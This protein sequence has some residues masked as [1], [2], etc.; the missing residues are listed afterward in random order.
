MT[1][2]IIDTSIFCLMSNLLYLYSFYF[3]NNS[4]VIAGLIRNPFVITVSPHLMP[5]SG[6]TASSAE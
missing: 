5:V 1:V 6:D 4:I 2:N 3:K